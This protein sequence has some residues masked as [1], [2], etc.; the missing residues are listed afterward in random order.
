MDSYPPALKLEYYYDKTHVANTC[1]T[2]DAT[3][4]KKER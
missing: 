1:K 4:Q 3:Y 2:A